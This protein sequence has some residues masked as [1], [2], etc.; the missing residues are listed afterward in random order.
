MS[1]QS[2][3]RFE[4]FPI[5]YVRRRGGKMYLEIR[6]PYTPALKELEHFSHVQVLWWISQFD[7]DMFRQTTQTDHTPYEAPTLGVFAC[8][9]PVRPNPI[10][11]TVAEILSVDQEQGLVQVRNLDAYD[12]TP[13]LDLKVY[14]PVSD[15]VE[16]V[17]VPDWMSDWPAWFPEEGLGLD[18]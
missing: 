4:L 6:A 8:R 17:R 13:I 11:L 18:E 12:D 14:I 15:R 3:E 5:G 1:E 2:V 9:S 7:E 16:T 10:G